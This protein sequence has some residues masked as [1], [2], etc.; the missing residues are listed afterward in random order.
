[1]AAEARSSHRSTSVRLSS[2]PFLCPLTYDSADGDQPAEASHAYSWDLAAACRPLLTAFHYLSGKLACHGLHVAIV[3]KNSRPELLP[4]W[5]I[6]IHAQHLFARIIQRANE[7]YPIDLNWL[8][9]L[10]GLCKPIEAREI[11]ESQRAISYIVHRSIAQ[12]DFIYSGDGLK[13]LA[14]DCIYTFKGLLA[15]LSAENVIPLFRDDCKESCVDLLHHVNKIYKDIQLSKGYLRR[16]Y[17]QFT[18]SE[19]ALEEVCE[20]YR[21]KFRSDGIFDV[22]IRVLD[23]GIS[24]V[25]SSEPRHI[26][27]QLQASPRKLPE[28][29]RTSSRQKAAQSRRA[30]LK[31]PRSVY[32]SKLTPP[33]EEPSTPVDPSSSDLSRPK[34]P[35]GSLFESPRSPPVTPPRSGRLRTVSKSENLRAES[36]ASQDSGTLVD[37]TETPPMMR[38]ASNKRVLLGPLF[39]MP[40]SRTPTAD[41][42]RARDRRGKSFDSPR[43]TSMSRSRSLKPSPEISSRASSTTR[44]IRSTISRYRLANGL[45][46]LA[47]RRLL[48]QPVSKFDRDVAGSLPSKGVESRFGWLQVKRR[49]NTSPVSASPQVWVF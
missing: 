23:S 49:K 16:A 46:K 20:A 15:E 17:T 37:Q 32:M 47:P 40:S 5:P 1:M 24:V 12:K 27:E 25:G 41:L 30:S 2:I 42:E 31:G 26:E 7:K 3:V 38:L 11:F 9:A 6:G 36:S 48:S 4:A 29:E 43:S 39:G 35:K 14:V 13:V 8:K 21:A 45:A 18:Y 44:S 10:L 28:S 22:S 34:S 33:F 19:E